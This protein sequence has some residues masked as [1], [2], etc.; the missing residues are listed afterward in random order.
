MDESIKYDGS[1][2]KNTVA[3]EY[4]KRVRK[5]WSSKLNNINKVQAHNTFAVPVL[6]KTHDQSLTM[7]QER[8]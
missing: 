7:D 6:T 1:L 3:S 2:N 8:D 4:R 5:I